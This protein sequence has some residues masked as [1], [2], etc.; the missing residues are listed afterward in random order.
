MLLAA[1]VVGTLTSMLA[2]WIPAQNAAGVDPVKALHKGSYEAYTAHESRARLLFA[3]LFGIVALICRL[4]GGTSG[5]RLYIGYLSVVIAAVLLT[6]IA[7]RWIIH[8]LRPLLRAI[9]PVE[10]ALAADSLMQAPRRT[11]ATVAAVM[12][13]LS[14]VIGLGGVADASYGSILDW[15][16]AVINP[17]LFVGTNEQ[18]SERSF[19]FPASLG[20]EI[21]AMD[22]VD[23]VQTVRS[24]RV[25]YQGT[26]VLLV[27]TKLD[28]LQARV[29]PKVIA[30][31]PDMYL[32]AAAGK[33]VIVADNLALLKNIQLGDTL[34]LAS[35]GGL[36]R[37]PVIGITIDYSDQQGAILMDASVYHKHWQDDTAN[38]FRVYLKDGVAVEDG[39]RRIL[40]RFGAN[41]RLF[42][43]T[44]QQLR[45]Y[46][47]RITDQWF[48]LTYMQIFVAV[49]VAIL[50]IVNSLTVS[51]T[52]R[53]RELGVLQAV[54]GLRRQVRQAIWMESFGI[55][56]VSTLMGLALG[57]LILFYYLGII[58][59]DM[60]GIRLEYIYPV[61]IALLLIP[62]MLLVAWVSAL[63]PAESAVRASLVE[64]LEYE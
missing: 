17:D 61:R 41:S 36:I 3:A 23:E 59:E 8:A 48:A 15:V 28:R 40:E 14:L 2:A 52:D 47:I 58:R 18:I 13:S 34:E 9:L 35:P 51:I 32:Q 12:L 64:A 27:V 49:L 45:D 1:L 62:T 11:S 5:A 21:A 44:N 25:M 33:G 4:S 10:G 55:G 24:T 37:L 30:G 29:K 26:P 42:V 63:G 53:R 39:K 38:L 22:I 43:M 6:P 20:N 56:L 31:A 54:G 57:A 50:G 60:A 7:V 19:R 46:I 16:N